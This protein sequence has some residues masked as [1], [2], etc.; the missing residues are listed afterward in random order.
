MKLP[1]LAVRIG[2]LAAMLICACG[3]V[4]AEEPGYEPLSAFPRSPLSIQGDKARHDFTVWVADTPSRRGQGLMFVKS[5]P[6]A[7]GMLF[8]FAEPQGVS[9][10]MKNTLIPL[11]M[12]FVAANGQ[13][14]HIAANAEPESLATISSMGLVTGVI[15]LAGG[16]AKRLGIH[17]GDRIIHPAFS[18]DP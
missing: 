6:P 11:D 9:M 14:I 5:L 8:V 15:E 18:K 10:W 4:V 13:V 17:T 2:S 3:I 1:A 12:L 7:T 16:E